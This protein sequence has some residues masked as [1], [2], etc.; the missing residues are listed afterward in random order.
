MTDRQRQPPIYYI[1]RQQPPIQYT[2]DELGR[3]PCQPRMDRYT[4][5]LMGKSTTANNMVA[6][7][8][9]GDVSRLS[10]GSLN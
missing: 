8:F 1:K 7:R 10:V 2:H 5:N 9:G 4:S 6:V 3:P